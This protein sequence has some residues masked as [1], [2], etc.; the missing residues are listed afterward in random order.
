MEK[1]IMQSEN[2]NLAKKT[3]QS[4]T[5]WIVTASLI[6]FLLFSTCL[7]IGL[8]S[9]YIEVDL[10][11]A[12]INCSQ[13]PEQV[14]DKAQSF[15]ITEVPSDELTSTS[16]PIKIT[17]KPLG[18]VIVTGVTST[19]AIAALIGLGIVSLPIEFALV[20]GALIASGSYIA[21]KTLY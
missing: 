9:Q 8:K 4:L 3:E 10:C 21:L 12:T 18:A 13:A 1:S 20:I 6:T 14:T 2:S 16:K 17:V 5:K 11:V 15:D 7:F 19:A